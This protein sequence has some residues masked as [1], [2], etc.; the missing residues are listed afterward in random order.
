MPYICNIPATSNRPNIFFMVVPRNNDAIFPKLHTNQLFIWAVDVCL[1]S[2]SWWVVENPIILYGNTPL[3]NFMYLGLTP[4]PPQED[5]KAGAT[6]VS[7]PQ[8][9]HDICHGG[10]YFRWFCFV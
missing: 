7:P 1:F 3:P 5:E 8:D 10:N 6:R 9:N 2:N 4:A